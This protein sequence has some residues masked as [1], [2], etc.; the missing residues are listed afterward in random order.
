MAISTAG[1]PGASV[2]GYHRGV[3]D[4]ILD[5]I[6]GRDSSQVELT[7]IQAQRFAEQLQRGE[8]GRIPAMLLLT[9][10][11][12]G[13]DPAALRTTMDHLTA[14]GMDGR[15]ALRMATEFFLERRFYLEARRYAQT[16]CYEHD[17]YGAAL[18]Q[19]AILDVLVGDYGYALSHATEY[20]ERNEGDTALVDFQL[21]ALLRSGA[22]MAARSLNQAYGL[23]P[24]LETFLG[25]Q[26]RGMGLG[27]FSW[28][29]ALTTSG[30]IRPGFDLDGLRGLGRRLLARAPLRTFTGLERLDEAINAGTEHSAPAL[31]RPE[32]WEDPEVFDGRLE[33]TRED[34]AA[35]AWV[36]LGRLGYPARLVIG[37]YLQ[38]E[39]NHAWVTIHR[40]RSVQVLECTPRGFNPLIKAEN[41]VEYRPWWSMDRNLHCYRH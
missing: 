19:L 7:E 13:R 33:G 36:H 15:F 9:Y 23:R 35:W 14:L 32:E 2:S 21:E 39:P 8:L 10:Q 30:E 1:A 22:L 20:L 24:R 16:W 25:R 40:G 11:A 5:V 17:R 41:A 31:K 18:R 3:L 34:F 37:G 6:W 38:K 4:V 27:R 29:G 28:P 12:Q 26:A